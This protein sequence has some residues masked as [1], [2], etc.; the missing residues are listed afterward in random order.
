M[1]PS[2]FKFSNVTEDHVLQ[3]LKDMNVDKAADIDNFSGLKRW[4][5]YRSKP[6]SELCNLSIKYSVFPK[7]CQIAKLKPVYKKGS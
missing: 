4:S 7:D 1:L 3:L 6:L 5:K 2:K